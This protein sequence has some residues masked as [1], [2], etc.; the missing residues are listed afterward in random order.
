MS[1][2][3]QICYMSKLSKINAFVDLCRQNFVTYK[4]NNAVRIRS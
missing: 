3:F 2:Y 1:I 4:N